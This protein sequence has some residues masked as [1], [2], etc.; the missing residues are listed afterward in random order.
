MNSWSTPWD[1]VETKCWEDCI[2]TVQLLEVDYVSI[3]GVA[4]RRK[5]RIKLE[6]NINNPLPNG[7][8]LSRPNKATTKVIFKYECM[9][10]FCYLCDRL[11]HIQQSCPKHSTILGNLPYV[12]WTHG[13]ILATHVNSVMI[14]VTCRTKV[15]HIKGKLSHAIMHLCQKLFHPTKTVFG[16]PKEDF[17][18]NKTPNLLES[19]ETLKFM[20]WLKP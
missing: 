7:F 16:Q 8:Q 3:F 10:K 19:I 6:I 9:F 13:I 17:N 12:H 5:L 15:K 11:D 18:S 14:L 20:W 2:G 1:I 4:L